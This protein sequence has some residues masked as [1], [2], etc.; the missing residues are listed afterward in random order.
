MLSSQLLYLR[1]IVGALEVE[2]SKRWQYSSTN[3][4]H[5][6]AESLTYVIRHQIVEDI[7]YALKSRQIKRSESTAPNDK[8]NPPDY[9][10]RYDRRW[11]DNRICSSW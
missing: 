7:V 5:F 2:P 10:Y 6:L 4:T 8:K 3:V 9:S 1:Y 11:K